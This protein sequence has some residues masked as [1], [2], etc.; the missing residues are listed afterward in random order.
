MPSVFQLRTWLTYVS[1]R[2]SLVPGVYVSAVYVVP[3]ILGARH[4]SLHFFLSTSRDRASTNL[5]SNLGIYA[6]ILAFW[7]MITYMALDSES[8]QIPSISQWTIPLWRCAVLDMPTESLSAQNCMGTILSILNT[9]LVWHPWCLTYSSVQFWMGWMSSSTTVYHGGTFFE[10]NVIGGV[11]DFYYRG[12]KAVCGSLSVFQQK[13][14]SG[15]FGF[16][17]VSFWIPEYVSSYM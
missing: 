11:L 17:P 7:Q 13:R 9:D 12:C 6:W 14:P 10:Y 3:V 8:T 1:L 15:S 4:V 5:F 16:P 2:T